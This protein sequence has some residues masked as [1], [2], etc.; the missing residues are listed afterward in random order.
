M[1]KFTI[2]YPNGRTGVGL[3]ITKEN[4]EELKKGHPIHVSLEELN[5][6]HKIDVM[7]MYGD[8]VEDIAK[9]VKPFIDE[10][11]IVHDTSKK[12]KAPN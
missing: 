2:Q 12:K 4:L 8:T 10:K 6:P 7:I 11:T 5:L 9:E 1:V 3:G